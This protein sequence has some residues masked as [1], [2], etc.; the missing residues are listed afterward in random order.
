MRGAPRVSAG[1]ADGR[2]TATPNS[3]GRGSAS[4]TDPRRGS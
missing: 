3:A 4:T 1:V 2:I